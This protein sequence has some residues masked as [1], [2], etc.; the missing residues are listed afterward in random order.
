MS[1]SETQKDKLTKTQKILII[2][3]V[4]LIAVIGVA[5]F[6]IIHKDDQQGVLVI[7]ESNLED[8]EEQLAETVAEG[9]F[10]VNM[11]TTWN[12][13]NATS[14]SS[15][16]YVANGKANTRAI[17]FEILVDGTE[18]VYSSTVIPVGK[19]IKEIIL[20]KKLEA[21]SYPALCLYH[22]LNEDGT[23]SSSCG[24]NITIN[25]AE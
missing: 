2:G 10:E 22:L 16:A 11:N 23:E 15:D 25:I 18:V 3:F 1:K 20:D 4:C 12:F 7:D 24:I 6:L 5:V 17:S 21:G 13:P 19:Q 9:T 14:A 8:V